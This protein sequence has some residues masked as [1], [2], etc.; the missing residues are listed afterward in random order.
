M[1]DELTLDRPFMLGLQ[2]GFFLPGHLLTH[3]FVAQTTGQLVNLTERCGV[4]TGVYGHLKAK[5]ASWPKLEAALI[6][7]D[8]LDVQGNIKSIQGHIVT[9]LQKIRVVRLLDANVSQMLRSLH[10]DLGLSLTQSSLRDETIR[11]L[12]C[13]AFRSAIV[14]GWNIIYAYLRTWVISDSSTLTEF[15][16][17]L[18]KK[19]HKGRP[20]Y[21]GIST[22]SAMRALRLQERDFLS[23]LRSV[24]GVNS[25]SVD[26]LV[27]SLNKRNKH[28]HA[29]NTPITMH[30]ANTYIE[31]LIVLAGQEF[32]HDAA[33]ASK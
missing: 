31:D 15:N 33:K 32:K 30:L 5:I 25:E 22:N 6:A 1:D 7:P 28:A 11:C 12:E 8:L 19:L 17:H 20:K 2:S 27:M 26:H 23:I 10:T 3:G 29:T 24:K 16:G 18:L 9:E 21:K 14:M 13:G 4:S